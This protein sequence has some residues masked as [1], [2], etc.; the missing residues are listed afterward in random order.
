MS[1]AQASK[2]YA[3]LVED[4]EQ[5]SKAVKIVLNSSPGHDAKYYAKLVLESLREEQTDMSKTFLRVTQCLPSFI[6]DSDDSTVNLPVS[7][8]SANSSK[9]SQN[10]TGLRKN[11]SSIT[12]RH[13][14]P[15]KKQPPSRIPMSNLT[16]FK[17]GHSKIK[18]P[19]LIPFLKNA[20]LIGNEFPVECTRVSLTW[21][22][23]G[24]ARGQEQFVTLKNKR[25]TEPTALSLQI[26][27]DALGAFSFSKSMDCAE[28]DSLY[29]KRSN[30][31]DLTL[32]PNCTRDIA[33]L[34]NPE[35]LVTPFTKAA[36]VFKPY[37][38]SK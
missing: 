18:N 28:D 9:S 19:A 17:I 5:V 21:V 1:L 23:L 3:N 11:R 29:Y 38:M 37:G 16:N 15:K 36:L 4:E 22:F 26:R 8:L 27:D 30:I 35:K 24:T 12:Q 31:I 20:D 7:I 10:S 32:G 2:D 13:S 6:G 25:K 33:V 14:S 34:C